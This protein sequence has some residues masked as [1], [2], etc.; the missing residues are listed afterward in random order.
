[1]RLAR[2]IGAFVA[3]ILTVTMGQALLSPSDAAGKPKH[4]ITA[5][6]YEKGNTDK[7]Y[8]KGKV[9]TFPSGKVKLLRKVGSGPYK[10][11]KKVK[12]KGDGKFKTRI[13]QVGNKDTCFKIQVPATSVYKKTTT[14]NLGCIQTGH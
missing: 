3:L 2:I 11:A 12:T 5:K 8:I 13:F 1:M 4:V 9:S 6:G 10:V 7:F 14:P